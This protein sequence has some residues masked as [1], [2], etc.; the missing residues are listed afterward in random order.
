MRQIDK[1]RFLKLA[2]EAGF[3][4]IRCNGDHMIFRHDDGRQFVINVVKPRSVV[5]NRLIKE[6]N[7]ERSL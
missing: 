1:R 6:F 7:L 5:M 3:R 4:V 2:R